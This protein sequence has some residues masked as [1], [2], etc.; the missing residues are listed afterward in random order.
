[1]HR[2]ALVIPPALVLLIFIAIMW[3]IASH[4]TYFTLV[5]GLHPAL[6]LILTMTGIIFILLSSIPFLRNKTTLNPMKPELTSVL[7][8]TGLYQ[9]SRNPIYLGFVIILLGWGFYLR[10]ILAMLLIAGFVFYMNRFQ[11][12]PEEKSLRKA[13]GIQFEEYERK[14][15]RWL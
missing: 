12:E 8:K 2:L 4:I 7:I 1:M 9:Y 13:F 6:P 10:N 15:P 3:I 11:I 14:V 5:S